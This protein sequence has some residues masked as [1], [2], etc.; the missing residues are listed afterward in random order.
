MLCR[1][2]RTYRFPIDNTRPTTIIHPDSLATNM[3]SNPSSSLQA[4]QRQHRRQN[5]T[6]SAFEGVKVPALPT[7]AQRQAAHRRGMSL[8]LRRQQAAPAAARQGHMV[9]TNTNNNTG[10]ATHP[11]HHVLREAQQ[12]RIQA[13]PG[14]QQQRHYAPLGH[15][16]S[17]NYLISPHGTPQ[18]QRFDPS[19]LDTNPI[20]FDPFGE[21][22]YSMM[23]NGQ[24]GP[25]DGI[26]TNQDFELFNSDSAL[27]TPTF[28]NF[29]ESP[30][31][32]GWISEGETASS[33]RSSRR[34]SNGIMDRVN[35]F[36]NLGIDEPRPITPPNQNVASM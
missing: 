20:P 29:S 11:Q 24:M 15:S 27:S 30:T 18:V 2:F 13:R 28:M 16:G 14:T 34:V 25:V 9:S 5:S 17:E 36:E 8:D 3:L 4:R 7:A 22:I 26:T 21:N 10:L 32:P 12:Q 19:C 31:A 6:P 33:K 35:K 23:Q 1:Q